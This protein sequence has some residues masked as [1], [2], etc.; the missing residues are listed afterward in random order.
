MA[1]RFSALAR[2]SCR[3]G[4]VL[5]TCVKTGG[6]TAAFSQRQRCWCA[7]SNGNGARAHAKK[8]PHSWP[9]LPSPSFFAA[10][11]RIPKIRGQRLHPCPAAAITQITSI[12]TF[13]DQRGPC[14]IGWIRSNTSTQWLQTPTVS[15]G[16]VAVQPSLQPEPR[17]RQAHKPGPPSQ[18]WPSCR[19][20][21]LRGRFHV[22][23]EAAGPWCGGS[24]RHPRHLDLESLFPGHLP[25]R[26]VKR[27]PAEES[28]PGRYCVN[29]HGAKLICI[30]CHLPAR[31]TTYTVI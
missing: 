9:D 2:A 12:M 10:H 17:A 25:V 20:K 27:Y 7:G 8:G 15:P 26:R 21:P 13:Q 1:D 19:P 29:L 14:F 18:D 6:S 22:A 4:G 24:I 30:S 3:I 28:T 23:W 31:M 11:A 16:L 5:Q